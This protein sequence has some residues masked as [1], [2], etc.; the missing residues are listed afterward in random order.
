MAAIALG[1]EPSICTTVNEDKTTIMVGG[2][3]YE[4]RKFAFDRVLNERASQIETYEE[5]AAGVIKEVLRGF[6]GAVLAYGQTGTGKTHTMF[7]NLQYKDRREP[8][9]WLPSNHDGASRFSRPLHTP[10]PL[11]ILASSI[12]ANLHSMPST[13]PLTHHSPTSPASRSSSGSTLRRLHTAG[14]ALHD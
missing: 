6:N 7:G 13:R 12:N 5:T 2:D 8:L 1:E 3:V 4:S 9:G 11:R 14:R 10:L